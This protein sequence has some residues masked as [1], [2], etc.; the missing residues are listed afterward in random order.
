MSDKQIQFIVNLDKFV[1][2]KKLKIEPKVTNTD[3][4]E[5]L[6]SIQFTCSQKIDDFLEK[7]FD[8]DSL[9]DQ[10]KD[11]LDLDFCEF[12]KQLNSLKTKKII[13]ASMKQD[14]EKKQKDAFVSA[15]K[16]YLL[17]RYCTKNKMIL[18]YNQI[19]FPSKKKIMK[20]RK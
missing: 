10:T 20:K 1:S 11:L 5:F 13:T 3:V 9:L 12:Y 18:S 8:T 14:L 17:N 15:C 7:I 19:L 6:G 4:V 16:I 2:V